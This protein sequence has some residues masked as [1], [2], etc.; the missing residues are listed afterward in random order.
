MNDILMRRRD[1]LAACGAAAV[2]CALPGESLWGANSPASK[3]QIG[4]NLDSLHDWSTQWSFVDIFKMSRPWVTQREGVQKWDTGETLNLNPDGYPLLTPGQRA[5]T[6]V[7]DAIQGHYPPGEYLCHYAG[8]GRI[9]FKFDARNAMELGSNLYAMDVTPSD[10]GILITILQSNPDNRVRDIK[11]WQR[12][13]ERNPI[14]PALFLERLAPFK[15]IRFMCWQ[16]T[17]GCTLAHWKDRVT[18]H[19]ARQNDLR[20]CAVEYMVDLCNTLNADPW[21]CMPHLADED[22]IRQFATLVKNTLKKDRKI[23]VEW[24]N[25]VWNFMFAQTKWVDQQAKKAGMSHEAMV[26]HMAS[27]AWRIWHEVF[28]DEKSRVVRVAA[29]QHYVP[30]RV[31]QILEALKGEFDAVSCAAYFDIS[32]PDKK[33]LN[34]TT[35]PVEMI[36]A[37]VANMKTTGLPL[38]QQHGDLAKQWSDRLGRHIPF[39]AYEGGPGLNP[40][41]FGAPGNLATWSG[42]A[43][44][45]QSHPMMKEAYKTWLQGF[46]D[47]GGEL[48]MAFSY[49]C[50]LSK[51]GYWG[52]LRYQDSPLFLSPKYMALIDW[53][54]S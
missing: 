37:L 40:F 23:Y 49:V 50:N 31:K 14:F 7:C 17:N 42:A 27:R 24:S 2:A 22:Y 45:C 11:L 18:T 32:E 34:E 15:T 16:N 9:E 46:A 25:E 36:E 12:T 20:G 28:G 10:R 41:Q 44:D 13:S 1:F 54:K 3:L 19:S 53:M 6:G 21:F 5:C 8:E 48:F 47:A 52:H 33:R 29:G 26:A 38:L 39:V 51:W 30:W 43:S 35:T 4:M